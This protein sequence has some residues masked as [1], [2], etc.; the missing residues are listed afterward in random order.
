[1]R[2]IKARQETIA[3]YLNCGGVAVYFIAWAVAAV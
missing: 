3:E 1:M 2:K